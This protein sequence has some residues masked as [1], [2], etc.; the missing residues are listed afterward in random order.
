MNKSEPSLDQ[1]V[2][3]MKRE[4]LV[5][6]AAGTLP[7]S[8]SSFSHL[9][10]YV[11]ANCY[12]GFCENRITDRLIAYFGGGDKNEGMPDGMLSYINEAQGAIDAWIKA[13]LTA[14]E[15]PAAVTSDLVHRLRA[16]AGVGLME[17]KTALLKS[18]GIYKLAAGYLRNSYFN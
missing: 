11:D 10:D 3:R 2:K 4:I 9:H 1:T 16:D 12:G 18:R 8:I 17:C 14:D 6:I 7:V 15:L 5:D 13:G